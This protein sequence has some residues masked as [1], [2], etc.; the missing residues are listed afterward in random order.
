MRSCETCKFNYKTEH[1]EPCRN[2]TH[3]AIDNYKPANNLDRIR[4]MRDIEL[5]EL[6]IHITV[7]ETVW[8]SIPNGGKYD[9]YDE[10]IRQTLVWFSKEVKDNE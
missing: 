7:D 9:T 5:A 8:Y 3:N 4:N 2:C 10:A 6:L 1:E